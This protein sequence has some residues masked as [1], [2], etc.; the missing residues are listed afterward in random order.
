MTAKPDVNVVWAEAGDTTDPGVPKQQ[1]GWIA[2]IPTFQIFNFELNRQGSFNAHVNEEGTPVWDALTDYPVGG[3]AKGST[4]LIYKSNLTPNIGNDPASDDG[5][6][7]VCLED[8]Q[9]WNAITSFGNL[10]VVKGSDGLLY[11]S[12]IP[13]NVGNDPTSDA[14]NW[15]PA[16]GT[17]AGGNWLG[18]ETS[19][20]V[21]IAGGPKSNNVAAGTVSD[22][23]PSPM[24]Q[25]DVFTVHSFDATEGANFTRIQ[26]N[27]NTILS[28]GIAIGG[29]LTLANGQTVKLVALST[30]TAEIV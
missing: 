10:Q 29:D 11:T 16:T 1:L 17:P 7:W 28:N 8:V 25:G 19:G 4:G 12:Q 5:T 30:S 3:R 22:S 15:N 27:G 23:L 20:S 24:V 18:P 9:V 21:L 26:E 6:N 2:E 13:S 14:V